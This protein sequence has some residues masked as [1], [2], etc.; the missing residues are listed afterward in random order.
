MFIKR[1]KANIKSENA[2]YVSIVFT[3]RLAAATA[4]IK[5]TTYNN[6]YNNNR[7]NAFLS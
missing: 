7:L 5:A 1:I 6:T 2:I 3:Q 4:T